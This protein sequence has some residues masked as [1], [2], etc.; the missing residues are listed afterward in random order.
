MKLIR[1][2]G[3][4]PH[5]GGKLELREKVGSL[6][7]GSLVRFFLCEDCGCSPHTVERRSSNS[8]LSSDPL[9]ALE[10]QQSASGSKYK[11]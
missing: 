3:L 10:A 6:K 1:D 5:C 11:P 8:A 4:C 7:T 2:A 9:A